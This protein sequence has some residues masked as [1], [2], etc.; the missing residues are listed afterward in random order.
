[1]KMYFVHTKPHIYAFVLFHHFIIMFFLEQLNVFMDTITYTDIGITPIL[2]VFHTKIGYM[3]ILVPDLHR[4][5][6]LLH[7]TTYY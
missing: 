3:N 7:N 4:L 6:F 5:I 1:M 2:S